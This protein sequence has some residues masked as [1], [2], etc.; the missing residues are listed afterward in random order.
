MPQA[1]MRFDFPVPL[2]CVFDVLGA[3][4]PVQLPEVPKAELCMPVEGHREAGRINAFVAPRVRG[5]NWFEKANRH[6]SDGDWR[7]WGSFL[8]G[9]IDLEPDSPRGFVNCAVLRVQTPHADDVALNDMGL[10][11]NRS[12]YQWYLR[13]RDWLEV[14]TLVDLGHE[15]AQRS[16]AYRSEVETGWWVAAP[17]LA[18]QQGFALINPPLTLSGR[19][20]PYLTKRDLHDAGSRANAGDRPPEALLLLRDA[21]AA[22]H[23][24]MYRRCVLDAA[25]A[26]EVSAS[27]L[28]EQ[29]LNRAVGQQAGKSLVRPRDPISRKVEVLRSFAVP[30]PQDLSPALFNVRNRV[31]HQGA[32]ASQGEARSALSAA[33]EA[34][35]ICL[36]AGDTPGN[37]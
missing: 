1:L 37:H 34:V 31:I 29:L 2:P 19:I 35:R 13:F 5:R 3:R 16:L 12:L 25:I 22:F 9:S 23:R 14:V 36:V 32:Q 21:R 11:V 28:L 27:A 26:V 24:D 7:G 8:P 20:S 33:T 10:T 6:F 15:H 18:G 4:I 30:L 17:R